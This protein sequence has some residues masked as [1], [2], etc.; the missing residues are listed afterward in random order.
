MGIEVIIIAVMAF[1]GAIVQAVIG[2][3]ML[4]F[5][6]PTLLIFLSPTT[7]ITA[8]LLAGLVIALIILLGE[9]RKGEIVANYLPYLVL[10]SLPGILIGTYILAHISKA[11]LLIIVGLTVIISL[12]LQQLSFSKPNPSYR[13]A[14]WMALTCFIAGIFNASTSMSGPALALWLR[15]FSTNIHEIRDT[16]SI[17]FIFLNIVSLISINLA[18]PHSI[19]SQS[20]LIMVLLVPIIVLGHRAG[21]MILKRI[22]VDHF[23]VAISLSI[24]TAGLI[25]LISGIT[26]L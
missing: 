25:G 5:L 11:Y 21:I 16:F 14:K 4:L 19:T 10:A 6:A 26:K 13:S 2:F 12:V 7:A 17:S 22:Q 24:L 15:S 1:I 23:R 20:L 18:K 8:A 3:G 9:R